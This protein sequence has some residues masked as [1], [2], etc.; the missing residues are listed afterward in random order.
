MKPLLNNLLGQYNYVFKRINN[1]FILA[2]FEITMKYKRTTLG[3]IWNVITLLVT[4]VLLSI[5]WSILF[6]IDL[7]E[8][9]PKVYFGITTFS[10]LT[11]AT[12]GSVQL[13][14]TTFSG[15]LRASDIPLQFYIFRH[16]IVTILNYLHYIP[17]ILILYFFISIPVNVNTLLL[18]PGFILLIFNFLWISTTM[19]IL[20]SRFRDL[21]PFTEAIMSAGTLITPILWDK[22]M[23][24]PYANYVYFNPFTFFIEG[25]KYPFM[26]VNPGYI[27]YLGMF[28]ILIL[29]NIIQY[30][31]IKKYGHR[32]PF[33]A[34]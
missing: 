6:K 24:G 10:F 14:S 34:S 1:I 16:L 13:V 33:W 30:L 25:I 9:L 23:L 12:T 5:V 11:M 4:T 17:I 19:S 32:I 3:P 8:Y 21:I 22:E 18:I 29:G 7:K 27:P 20:G 26:G 15:N 2:Y 28:F 31:I